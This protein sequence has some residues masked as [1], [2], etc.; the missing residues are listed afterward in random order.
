MST[1][2]VTRSSGRRSRSSCPWQCSD[3]Q[4]KGYDA[5]LV[6]GESV[7]YLWYKEDITDEDLLPVDDDNITLYT[8]IN[9]KKHKMS[10]ETDFQC[11]KKMKLLEKQFLECNHCHRAF[12]ASCEFARQRVSNDDKAEWLEAHKDTWVCLPCYQH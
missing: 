12:H 5:F 11:C 6:R 7:Y 4:K 2:F 3:A 8:R 10:P 9:R 1:S